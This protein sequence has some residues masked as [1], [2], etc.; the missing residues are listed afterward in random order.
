M[1]RGRLSAHGRWWGL[2]VFVA[3]WRATLRSLKRRIARSK[4][5]ALLII[6][7][8]GRYKRPRTALFKGVLRR[9]LTIQVNSLLSRRNTGSGWRG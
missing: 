9:Y 2:A 4:N 5:A 7:R 8:L 3:T 6:T 1:Q